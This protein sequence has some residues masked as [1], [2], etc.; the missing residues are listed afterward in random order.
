MGLAL[1]MWEIF[2]CVIYKN[3]QNIKER[4]CEIRENESG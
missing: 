1:K 4:E 2:F 3:N